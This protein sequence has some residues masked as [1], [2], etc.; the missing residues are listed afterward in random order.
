MGNGKEKVVFFGTPE[1]CIPFL[2]AIKEN[3][4]LELI[5]TQPDSFGGRKKRLIEP[6]A[7]KFAL[8]NIIPFIQP[9]KLN[10]E[11]AEKIMKLNPSIAVV[12]SYGKLIP[13]KIFRIP[14]HKTINVHFSLLPEFRGAAPVQRV[15][16]MGMDKT[17]ITIFEIDKG[18]DTGDIWARKYYDIYPNDT[19]ETLLN[20]LSIEGSSFLINTLNKIITGKIEKVSQENPKATYARIVK[21]G[22]GRIDWDLPAEKIFNR[23][24][25]FYPWPGSYFFIN[26]KKFTIT[27]ASVSDEK[28]NAAPGDI[29]AITKE[30]MEVCCGGNSVLEIMSF[31]PQGKKEMAPYIFSLGTK[32]PEKL[33]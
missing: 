23:F 6:A 27:I 29:Y 19:S 30:K 3:F 25:A 9:E 14:L 31:I 33:H 12:V 32:I 1:I 11:I 4:K 13:E 22:E 24:R 7:K 28:C 21:K 16:E 17:G 2:K 8:Q 26:E 10:S 18:M 15:I 5:I 20:R